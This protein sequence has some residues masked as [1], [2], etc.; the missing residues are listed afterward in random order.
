[1]AA[2]N[3]A[4]NSIVVISPRYCTPYQVDLY[5]A[6]RV[7]KITEGRHLGVFDINGNNIFKVITSGH[8]SSRLILA[9]A[10]GVP[11]VSLKPMKWSPH[12]RWKVY[13]G[14]SSDSKDLLL[15]VK[16]SHYL[17][18]KIELDVF[19]ASNTT[20]KVCNF[21][22]KQNLSEKSCIIYQGNSENV[23]AE[24]HKNK[25]VRDKVQGKDTFLVT[26]NQNVDSAFV[27]AIAAVLNEVN[28]PSSMSKGAAGG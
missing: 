14:D 19:L 17:Q 6:K 24:M 5:I 3:Q 23:I 20:E 13:D 16:K 2:S 21:K 25:D 10:A 1:M 15:T 12:Q 7:K 22:V 27:V 18:F 4:K 9:D 8:F 11:V 28:T 26:V